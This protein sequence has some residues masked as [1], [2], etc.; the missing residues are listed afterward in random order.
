MMEKKA[1]VCLHPFVHSL[2]GRIFLWFGLTVLAIIAVTSIVSLATG[3]GP[4][5][6]HLR[7]GADALL[8]MV[9][10]AVKSY[11]LHGKDT[12]SQVKGNRLTLYSAKAEILAGAKP[13]KEAT[14]LVKEALRTGEFQ[15]SLS[16]YLCYG[17][18][19]IKTNKGLYV[20]LTCF[21]KHLHR[22]PMSK[23]DKH[24][25]MTRLLL[26]I[27][28]AALLC[29]LLARSL[30]YPLRSLQVATHRIAD[31]DLTTRVER[32]VT[33]RKDEIGSLAKDFNVMTERLDSLLQ[34]Q[35]RLLGDISHELRSP[36]T[37]LNVA[38]E[39][40]RKKVQDEGASSSLERIE[41][42]ALRLDELIGEVL[43]LTKLRALQRPRE[44]VDVDLAQ[45]IEEVVDDAH[46]EAE[47]VDKSVETNV[48]ASCKV[49]GSREL[50]R[51]ALENVVRNGVKYT[52]DK[53]KILVSLKTE[54]HE[55]IIS[56][57]DQGKGVDEELLPRL[58]TPFFR[59]AP[60]R[61]RETGGV[62]LGL[63]ITEGAVLLHGGSVSA[64]NAKEGGF[65]VTIKLPIKAKA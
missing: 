41:Q 39:L 62:G 33:L 36:L 54:D 42:E 57:K 59:A 53:T 64:E 43:M 38:L 22:H 47:S 10:L 5:Q 21:D 45:L 1:N 16:H 48:A 20:L 32:E 4:L 26:V 51:R 30:S 58:F 14:E 8:P 40:A 19:P 11:E 60:D 31:G 13:Q 3:T 63:A 37:R 24:T 65:V 6:V 35:R 46:F 12:F 17:A 56:V 15:I 18:L 7:R 44:Q 28:T 9:E 29:L 61:D 34:A 49:I 52:R 23:E 27:A 55:A 25:L 50:L 2:F